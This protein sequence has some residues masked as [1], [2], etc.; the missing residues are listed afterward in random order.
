MKN[1]SK[2]FWSVISLSLVAL[3][4]LSGCAP[5]QAAPPAPPTTEKPQ[6]IVI[7]II[8]DIS[9]PRAATNIITGA[10]LDAFPEWYNSH[11]GLDGVP[12]NVEVFDTRADGAAAISAYSQVRDYQPKPLIVGAWL[13][14]D[15]DALA[16]RFI[17][18]KIPCAGASMSPQTAWPPGWVFT[19]VGTY[20]EYAAAFIDWLSQEWSKSGETRKCRLAF[21]NPDYAAG[22]AS[23]AP[24]V[25]EYLETKPNIELVANEF[26]SW[27]SLDVSSEIMR[28]MQAELDWLFGFYFA[29][30]GAAFFK[31][32]DASGYR[33]KVKVG[34]TCWGM[35]DM[36]AQIVGNELVEGY[37]GP[38]C[39]SP[40]L[41]PGEEQL[42]PGMDLVMQM[43]EAG[44]HPPEYRGGTYVA[45]TIAISWMT[46]ALEETLKQVGWD[47]LDGTAVYN[48]LANTTDMDIYG[49]MKW[50]A[51]KG[52]RS[53]N[54]YQVYQFRDGIPRPITGWGVYPDLRPS[55]FRT[56]EYNW[57]ATGWP[58][59]WFK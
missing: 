32:L 13:A 41:P 20:P 2:V 42:T 35:I 30:S 10:V 22:Q 46:C 33:D 17:E 47:K 18:D 12:I 51:A 48:T 16:Q 29:T 57:E 44:N 28:V 24:E 56:T 27:D 37:T 19:S 14:S 39:I 7:P 23:A 25:L 1:G 52:T 45:A 40:L 6:E 58:K 34:G 5:K 50:G 9:G 3:I 11:G 53:N 15:A 26:F 55:E 31:S 8:H 43:F 49:I 54:R 59:D 4:V 36:M 21:L 38:F